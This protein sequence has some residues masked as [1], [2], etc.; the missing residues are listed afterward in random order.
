MTT[1]HLASLVNMVAPFLL[2]GMGWLSYFQ[3][4]TSTDRR[5]GTLCAL[6]TLFFT[7]IALCNPG[8]VLSTVL[9]LLGGIGLS[10]LNWRGQIRRKVSICRLETHWHNWFSDRPRRS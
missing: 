2:I 9:S 6:T 8:V 10:M 3:A 7:A 4:Q 1:S 5:V